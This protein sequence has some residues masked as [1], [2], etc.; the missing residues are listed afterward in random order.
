MVIMSSG[1]FRSSSWDPPLIVAQIACL[2]SCFY[3]IVSIVTLVAEA[4]ASASVSTAHILDYRSFRGDTV[5]GWSLALGWELSAVIT[6][7]SL[8]L[9]INLLVAFRFYG[10]WDVRDNVWISVLLCTWFT[11]SFLTFIMGYSHSRYFGGS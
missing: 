6:Y 7:F 4:I 3:V 2:Q 10:L 8:I 5:L 1:G 11:C 9:V